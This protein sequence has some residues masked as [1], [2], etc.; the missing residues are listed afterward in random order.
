MRNIFLA[1]LLLFSITKSNAQF[2]STAWRFAT[3]IKAEDLRDYLMFIASQGTEGR[4]TGTPGLRRAADYIASQYG[5]FGVQQVAGSGTYYQT[6]KY[7]R[8]VSHDVT[9]YDSTQK[10]EYLKDFY[11]MPNGRNGL[12]YNKQVVFM[13]YGIDDKNFNDYLKD[14]NL[15]DKIV[16]LMND[17]PYRKNKYLVSG[18]P[19]HS[20]WYH[21]IERKIVRINK[22]KP[23]ALIIID[24]EFTARIS[25]MKKELTSNSSPMMVE[26]INPVNIPV[27]YTHKGVAAKLLGIDSLRLEWMIKKTSKK[28]KPIHFFSANKISIEVDR[29]ASDPSSENVIG[30]VE[31]TDLK[32]E[33]IVISAHYDHLGMHKG[34]IFYGADDDGSGTVALLELAQAFTI[35]KRSGFAPRRSIIFCAFSGEEK[36]L[37][38]SGY[39][40]KNSLV[41][42]NKIVLN[43]NIDMIGRMDSTYTALNNPNYVYPIGSNKLASGLKPLLEQCNNTY[44]HLKLDY[45]YDDPE[46]KNRFY[47]RSDHYNFAKNDIPVVFFFNGTHSDYHKSTDTI[48]KINFAKMQTITRLVYYLAWQAASQNERLKVDLK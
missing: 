13:G 38:G 45:R 10:F 9:L 12:A 33:Y 46:D 15:T 28:R 47:Y 43:L 34:K 23:A 18:T 5:L 26:S 29:I 2:D 27:L 35:A 17:E 24:D 25:A 3:T 16:I 21:N 20:D 19:G 8:N 37:L 48:E 32:D 44:T 30:Y 40:V 6:Y 39:F 14:T 41:P 36:G 11:V 1:A 31:G 4:E 7:I 42:L 22:Y